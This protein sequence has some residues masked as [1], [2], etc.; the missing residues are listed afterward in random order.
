MA[1]S[2]DWL[3]SWDEVW[4]PRHVAR[5]RAMCDE[6]GAHATPFVH[7]DLVRGWLAAMGGPATFD[8]FFLHARHCRRPAGVL[9]AG[10]AEARLAATASCA[11]WCRRG[12][13]RADRIS[14]TTI[15]WSCRRWR[16]TRCLR[17]ASGRRSSASFARMR[18][19]G[20]TAAASPHPPRVRG[21]GRS[22]DRSCR[23]RPTFGWTP[24]PT[25]RPMRQPD[26]RGWPAR[27]G[28]SC[29]GWRRTDA[30]RSAH[31]RPRRAE[32]GAGLAPRP[33]G[34]AAGAVSRERLPPR[35][36]A[37]HRHRR[38]STAGWCAARC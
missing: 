3:R 11:G 4:D 13:G 15:R 30:A 27:S 16:R 20:S 5:W 37:E 22:A 17:A 25:S 29:V 18:G 7:P 9:A 23:G 12:T 10:P 28:A 6:P 24:T 8:P 26:R 2:F 32:G 33:R 34:G 36:P 19:R 14:P 21:R 38:G 31:A 35:V 1:W